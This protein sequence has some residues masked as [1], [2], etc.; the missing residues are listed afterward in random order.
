VF[1]IVVVR[2]LT[3]AE[4]ARKIKARACCR[5][6]NEPL[7][8]F[9]IR[10]KR[11]NLSKCYVTRFEAPSQIND[12]EQKMASKTSTLLHEGDPINVC[13]TAGESL[14]GWFVAADA[15]GV[16][17][18]WSTDGEARTMFPWGAV[19]CVEVTA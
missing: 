16:W 9:I 15:W 4:K 1:P 7:L 11:I 3:L 2:A 14:E 6:D 12:K 13:T 5:I 10:P 8:D 17:L 18:S 19:A